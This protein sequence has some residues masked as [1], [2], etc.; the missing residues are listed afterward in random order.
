MKG[1]MMKVF[2]MPAVLPTLNSL[3]MNWWTN[4]FT[5]FQVELTVMRP[6]LARLLTNWSLLQTKRCKGTNNQ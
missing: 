4:S 6:L 2:K 1:V 5:S 3:F